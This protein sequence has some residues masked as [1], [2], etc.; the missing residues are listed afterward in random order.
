[1]PG[2]PPSLA[3]AHGC[4]RLDACGGEW[5]R[6]VVFTLAGGVLLTR[7]FGIDLAANCLRSCG[8]G[9]LSPSSRTRACVVPLKAALGAVID[10]ALDV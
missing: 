8:E 3:R 1:M 6:L 9:A 5:L 2:I 10:V 7:L 4:L